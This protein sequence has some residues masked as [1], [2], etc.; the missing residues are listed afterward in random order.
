V[1]PAETRLHFKLAQPLSIPAPDAPVPAAP[2]AT[3]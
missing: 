2:P 1:L 3:N